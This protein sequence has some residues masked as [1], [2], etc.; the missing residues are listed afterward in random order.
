MLFKDSQAF[1]Q[2]TLERAEKPANDHSIRYFDELINYKRK[3]SKIYPKDMPT[4]FI[5]KCQK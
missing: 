5:V 1:A 2:F 3:K 4:F